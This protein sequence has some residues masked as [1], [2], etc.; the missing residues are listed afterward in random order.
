VTTATN[1]LQA[2]FREG[3]LIP[4]G[5]SASTS[6]MTEALAVLNR[7]INAIFGY[8]LGEKLRDWEVPSNQFTAPS[9]TTFPQAPLNVIGY[10]TSC[11]YQLPPKN[12]RIIFGGSVNQT[13]YFP[14]NP[15]DGSRMAVI[16]GAVNTPGATITLNGNGRFIENAATQTYAA[17]VPARGWLYRADLG[18]WAACPSRRTWTISLSVRCPCAWRRAMAKSRRRRPPKPRWTP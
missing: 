14:S 6:E 9:P 5:K 16:Q 3:N 1:I 13:V 10:D 18:T 11:G 7:Y 15:M 2:G 4:A 12:S 8:E 17:P